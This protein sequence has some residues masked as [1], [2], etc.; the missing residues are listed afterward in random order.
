MAVGIDPDTTA[1]MCWTKTEDGYKLE[2]LQI[3][4]HKDLFSHRNGITSPAW[5][6]EAL[7]GILPATIKEKPKH[8]RHVYNHE[9]HLMIHKGY[10]EYDDGSLPAIDMS[11]LA[12]KGDLVDSAVNAIERLKKEGYF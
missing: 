1:D 2:V 11:F 10:I 6:L 9:F 4:Y 3:P 7:I 5:S 8:V 12:H